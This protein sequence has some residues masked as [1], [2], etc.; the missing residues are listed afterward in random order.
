MARAGPCSALINYGQGKKRKGVG[1]GI[2][3]N[4]IGSKYTLHALSNIVLRL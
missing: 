1:I 4:D 3:H 2:V